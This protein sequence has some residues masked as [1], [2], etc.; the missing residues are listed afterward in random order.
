MQRSLTATGAAQRAI[1][2]TTPEAVKSIMLKY[3]D[4][5]QQVEATPDIIRAPGLRI[6]SAMTAKASKIAAEMHKKSQMAEVLCT[7]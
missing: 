1:V 7:S 5:L 3:I 6:G 4:F 2:C